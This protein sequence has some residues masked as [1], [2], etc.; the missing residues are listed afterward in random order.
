MARTKPA[1]NLTDLRQIANKQVQ[2]LNQIRSQINQQIAQGASERMGKV[3]HE[4]LGALGVGQ[5]VQEHAA[6]KRRLLELESEFARVM[7]TNERI[8]AYAENNRSALVN[9]IV[10]GNTMPALF[11][12]ELEF[13]A[14]Q[15]G[16][17]MNSI[18]QLPVVDIDPLMERLRTLQTVDEVTH[19]LALHQA[20]ELIKMGLGDNIKLPPPTIPPEFP[21]EG[22][23]N[24]S[25]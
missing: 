9:R 2:A 13:V 7:G 11:T 20:E 8:E 16:L 14:R 12:E 25:A 22:S 4:A 24:G 17:Q 10:M 15:R 5:M 6:L 18:R 3:V 1:Y 23:M 21:A 19:E